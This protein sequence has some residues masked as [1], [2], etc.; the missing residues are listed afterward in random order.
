MNAR[1]SRVMI[2]LPANPLPEAEASTIT[3]LPWFLS[4]ATTGVIGKNLKIEVRNV[5][6]MSMSRNGH[7]RVRGER[8]WNVRWN[9]TRVAPHPH[10]EEGR[11]VRITA[12]SYM[13]VYY[14]AS[15]YRFTFEVHK[16]VTLPSSDPKQAVHDWHFASVMQAKWA[17]DTIRGELQPIAMGTAEW[18]RD[19]CA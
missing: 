14:F 1:L 2:Q 12:P 3:R 13:T 7:F 6:P 9:R 15:Y 16:I 11:V 18:A 17:R 10:P 5:E 8:I 19:P 4:R